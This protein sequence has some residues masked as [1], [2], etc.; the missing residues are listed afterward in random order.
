MAAVAGHV[1]INILAQYGEGEPREIGVL[2][3]PVKVN[4]G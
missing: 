4:D 2:E 1:N 3:V